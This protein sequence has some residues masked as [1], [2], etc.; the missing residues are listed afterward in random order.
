LLSD[1]TRQYEEDR[2][3]LSVIGRGGWELYD[4]VQGYEAHWR[5]RA[6][7]AD[8]AGDEPAATAAARH[9]DNAREFGEHLKGITEQYQIAY[10]ELDRD[11]ALAELRNALRHTRTVDEITRKE[12]EAALI[13]FKQLGAT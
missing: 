7:A 10:I 6:T 5:A 13:W 8:R 4:W 1:P 11:L 3:P 12:G 2:F 9:A